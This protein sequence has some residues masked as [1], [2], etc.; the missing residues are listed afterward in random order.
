MKYLVLDIE[1]TGLLP[2]KHQ[3]L[4]IGAVIDDTE[5]ELPV[6]E[7]PYYHA[8][9]E[10]DE[11]VGQ[12]YALKMN[13]NILNN[14]EGMRI[15]NAIV[16]F[17][18]FILSHFPDGKFNIAG[19]NVMSFDWQFI[20]FADPITTAGLKPR[21]RAIDPAILFYQ[22]GDEKL[23]DLQEC[24]K[25]AGLSALVEHTALADARLTAQIIRVGLSE[26]LYQ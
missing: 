21:H 13:A 14:P 19:K 17:A 20:K 16:E 25:R 9:I 18:E 12:A 5:S 22:K 23:P 1:T 2:H 6:E 8:Y 4:E 15:S 26:R 11:I 3:I 7:L 24:A 10:W